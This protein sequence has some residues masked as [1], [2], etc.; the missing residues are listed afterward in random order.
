MGSGGMKAVVDGGGA[1]D[2][3]G[4]RGRGSGGA[5]NGSFMKIKEAKMGGG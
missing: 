4:V 2:G 1:V 3:S 5:V